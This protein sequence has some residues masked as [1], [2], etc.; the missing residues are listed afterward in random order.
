MTLTPLNLFAPTE[1]AAVAERTRADFEQGVRAVGAML[2]LLRDAFDRA[3]EIFVEE[4]NEAVLVPF[5]L[6]ARA[7]KDGEIAVRLLIHG[8]C[9]QS[10]TLVR[11]ML[12]HLLNWLYCLKHPEA[13]AWIWDNG[14]PT[15]NRYQPFELVKKLCGEDTAWWNG[16]HG[17]YT[18]LSA[19][20]HP[21]LHGIWMELDREARAILTGPSYSADAA[22]ALLLHSGDIV[23]TVLAW[24]GL[25]ASPMAPIAYFCGQIGGVVLSPH[26]LE[27]YGDWQAHVVAAS[28]DFTKWRRSVDR[29]NEW[30]K[31]LLRHVRS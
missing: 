26:R 28:K 24:Y 12:E 17:V 15:G 8:Y 9:A 23:S 2:G 6:L 16:D 5:A 11:S 19:I 18:A 30:P 22:R 7:Y 29:K 31:K 20:A 4:G 1:E 27:W 10:A 13:Q 25:V 21:N 3:P 14:W